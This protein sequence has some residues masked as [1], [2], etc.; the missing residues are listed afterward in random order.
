MRRVA[1]SLAALSLAAGCQKSSSR[2]RDGGA[3]GDAAAA[4]PA[5]VIAKLEGYRDAACAC[6]SP[7]CVQDVEN[8]MRNWLLA[9]GPAMQDLKGTPAQTAAAQKASAAMDAC[10]DRILHPTGHP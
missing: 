7:A 4:D 10:V 1:L 5:A 3:T 8:D 6:A 2:G 9:V